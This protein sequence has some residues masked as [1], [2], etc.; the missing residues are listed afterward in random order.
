MRHR[1]IYVLLC[2]MVPFVF[3]FSNGPVSE[4]YDDASW[5]SKRVNPYMGRSVSLPKSAHIDLLPFFS[6]TDG[7][8]RMSSKYG[9]RESMG[10]MHRGVDISIPMNTPIYS[11]WDG[12]VRTTGYEKKGY[13][14]YVVVRH[15]NGLETVYAHLNK[16]LSFRGDAVRAGDVIGLSG[17]SG[18]STGPH[19]HFETRFLGGDFNP[20]LIIDFNKSTVKN[21][22]FLWKKSLY[23]KKRVGDSLHVYRL[24]A[25]ATLEKLCEEK[26]WDLE[27]LCLLNGLLPDMELKKGRIVRII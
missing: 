16:V 26:N 20:S 1:I 2:L 3:S 19:L 22:T 17:N 15:Y 23:P 25:D 14:Y 18:R 9:W 8:G 24:K 10:R 12:V 4:W 5:A 13:G 11:A 6:P 27:E 21:K 7:L